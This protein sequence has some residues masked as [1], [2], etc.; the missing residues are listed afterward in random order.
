MN[1]EP[2]PAKM[3][4]FVALVNTLQSLTN[5]TK[6]ANIGAMGVLN[7]SLEYYNVF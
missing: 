6:N 5:F 1:R 4:H 3:E 7:A 2:S